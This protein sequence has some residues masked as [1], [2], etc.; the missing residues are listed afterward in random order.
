[1][2]LLLALVC[3]VINAQTTIITYTATEKIPRFE[4]IQ[5]FVG[6]TEVQSH[7]FANGEGTVVYEGTVTEFD[8]RCLQWTSA[9][10]GIV[11]PE[12]VT[13]LGFQAFQGCSNLTT[14]KLPKSLT[15]IGNPTGLVFDGCSGLANGQFII[16]D[17]AWWCNLDIRGVFSNPLY[18]AKKFYSAPDVEVTNL[19]IPEGVISIGGNAFYRCEGITSVTLPSTLTAIGSNAFA[20]TNIESVAIPASVTEIEEGTFKHCA[21]LTSVTIPEG[22]TTIGGSA[23]ANSGLTSLTLP[24]T[25]TSMS[26]SFY[27]CADLATLT[28]TP[29]ITTLGQS[30]Y[31]CPKLTTVNIPGSIKEIGSLDF[32]NCTGLT[33]VVLNEGTEEVSFSGCTNLATINFPSTIKEIYFKNCSSLETVTLQEGVTRIGGFEGCSGLDQ[34]NIPSTVTYVGTFKDCNAL[35]KVIIADVASWC[36]ARH[37]DAQYYGPTLMAGKLY[38]GTVDN[39]EEIT[40]LVI[41]EGVTTIKSCSFY[42]LPN[43]T[44]VTIPSS[45]TSWENKAF[46]GCTGITDVWCLADPITLTWSES[47]NNFKAEKE[48]QMHVLEADLWSS[49]FPDANSTFVGDL[50]QVPYTATAAVSAFAADKF[51]G[52]TAMLLNSFD[53]E[54]GKG[55]AI[56]GGNLTGVAANAFAGSTSLTSI[57]LPDGIATIGSNAFN[58][59]TALATI[60]LP[61]TVTT[62]SA[63]AFAGLTGTTDVWCVA[64]PEELTWDGTGFKSGKATTMHVMVADDWTTKFP[65]A[66]VTFQGDMTRFR[67]TAT[68]KDSK[69]FYETDN[70]VGAT[71]MAAHD[72]NT[73]TGEGS[74]IFKGIV[75]GL[76]YRTFYQNNLLT[77]MVIPTTVTEMKDYIFNGCSNLTTVSLPN[78]ITSMGG[79]NFGKCTSLTTV[80]IPTSLNAIPSSTF[81]KCSS[82]V[83]I[84]IPETITDIGSSAFSN[85]T[86]LTSIF[87]PATVTQIGSHAFEACSN[88]AKVIT[89]DLAVWCTIDYSGGNADSNPLASARHLYVGSKASN[90]EVTDLVIP[91]G[92]AEIKRLTFY[93]CEGL[94]SITIPATITTIGNWGYNPFHG[95]TNVTAI[96]ACANPAALTW[97]GNS[98]ADALMPEKETQVHVV[99]PAAWEEAF[100]EVN[101]TFIED[102]STFTYTAT[103]QVTQFSTFTNFTG[104]Y[105]VGNH[106]Y[107]AE[108]Q[109]GTVDF[110]GQVTAI[111]YHAFTYNAALTS[112]VIPATVTGMEYSV[113]SHCANLTTVSLPNTITTMG[114]SNFEGCSK[115]TTVNIPTGLSEI[116]SFT[117]ANC[118]SLT[119]ITI[120][121]NISIINPRAFASTA[122]TTITIPAGV[123]KI[124]NQAFQS[125]TSLTK[126]VTP[127]LTAWCNIGFVQEDQ[128][129]PT[130]NPLY[131]AHHLF[132][133][134]KEVAELVIPDAV[135]EIKP[136]AFINATALTKVTIPAT[137]TTV[138]SNAFMGCTG[139]T[140][141]WCDAEPFNTWE[142][143]NQGF[144]EGK[145]TYM[146]VAQPAAWIAKYPDAG[147]TY[148]GE[149]T[150]YEEDDNTAF[151]IENDGLLFNVTLNRTVKAGSYNTF[152]VPFDVDGSQMKGVLGTDAKVKSLESSLYDSGAGKLTIAFTDAESIGHGKPYMVNVEADVVNPTFTKVTISKD[153]I[154]ATTANV[155]FVP[156]VGKTLVTGPAGSE[157]DTKSVLLLGE[158]NTLGYPTVVNDDSDQ[159]SYIKGF[160]AYFQ[161]HNTPLLHTTIRIDLGDGTTGI[162]LINEGKARETGEWYRL[163]G[164]QLEVQ[165]VNK[166][167]YIIDGKKV[168]VK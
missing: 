27:G 127:S 59:C 163:D 6:A 104:A 92:V 25:I 161:L 99:N 98:D 164:R 139:V 86:G 31:N 80:N 154:P 37:Y 157:S 74:V 63:N 23:F 90:T 4:E 46:N 47:E 30:F 36:N 143:N 28:L 57:T 53:A 102:K 64:E 122:L 110:V 49:K 79:S 108:T 150:L 121:E 128:S 124:R 106:E 16:D 66:N 39:N 111:K 18:Y 22:V 153:I 48:T 131:Y 133:G 65:D 81:Y 135:T 132:V 113:F 147:V 71:E 83:D 29:G 142:T 82:L 166:G 87:I 26:Q 12:G 116:P 160:R 84:D 141:V 146:H 42:G 58:G 94:T 68:A 140:D 97:E 168:L 20:Y 33:T 52:A 158:G 9:L 32:S 55:Y 165:P 130:S 67:Y 17:I 69:S 1:M 13:N 50:T 109:I 43:I 15:T 119:A 21:N 162:E 88:L 95:C 100:P 152:A 41:P 103:E 8:S 107:N 56:F 85:C 151:L 123:T 35:E 155:D 75:T 54:A 11:I 24:S 89:P 114:N 112:I 129:Y 5:Y 7:T 72:Y 2:T 62:F 14:I 115:L 134:D 156:A 45:L 125:C 76:K 118:A 3:V 105:G 144:K 51:T 60:T 44:S 91:D 73:A 136:R 117:F 40:N 19:V 10:T 159:Y 70:F 61:K 77:S 148:I 167:I 96:Y 138:R 120:P 149:V 126:V 34:I 38:L 93:N 137:V 78:T 145:Q 101:A